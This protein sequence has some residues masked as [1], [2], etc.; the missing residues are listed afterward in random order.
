[1]LQKCGVAIK[2]DNGRIYYEAFEGQVTWFGAPDAEKVYFRFR[3]EQGAIHGDWMN[4]TELI[5]KK[6]EFFEN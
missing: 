6:P 2:T 4:R 1:L 3:D 5:E